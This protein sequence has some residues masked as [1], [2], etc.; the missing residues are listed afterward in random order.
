[1]A[2]LMEIVS[3][4]QRGSSRG[5]RSDALA[6]CE[7]I[8]RCRGSITRVKRAVGLGQTRVGML[9]SAS[10]RRVNPRQPRPP[11]V[12]RRPPRLLALVQPFSTLRQAAIA[13]RTLAFAEDRTCL[14]RYAGPCRRKTSASVT[15]ED[16]GEWGEQFQKRGVARQLRWRQTQIARGGRPRTT[17]P[18]SRPMR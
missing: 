9:T 12:T 4:P 7:G 3:V 6:G 11:G 2:V 16:S 1:M 14:A 10:R 5:Q 17:W 18:R 8:S 13:R 15:G